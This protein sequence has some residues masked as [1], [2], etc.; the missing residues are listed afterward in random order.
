MDF[1]LF[2]I[3]LLNFPVPVICGDL[4]GEGGVL[5]RQGLILA[6]FLGS[7]LLC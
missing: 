5:H 4:M 3:T 6:K 1:F 2:M 7:T